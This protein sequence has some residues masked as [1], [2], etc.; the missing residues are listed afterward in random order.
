MRLD[1][2][3]GSQRHA[4]LLLTR[5]KGDDQMFASITLDTN[6]FLPTVY[7]TSAQRVECDDALPQPPA[8]VAGVKG[9][10]P[11][12]ELSGQVCGTY[13][14]ALSTLH[15][16]RT[17]AFLTDQAG[18]KLPV[19]V[20][21]WIELRDKDI[22]VGVLIPFTQV[23]SFTRWSNKIFSAG[24]GL[25]T[26]ST[27]MCRVDIGAPQHVVRTSRA[28]LRSTRATDLFP[29]RRLSNLVPAEFRQTYYLYGV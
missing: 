15:L 23:V 7:P 17:E 20:F 29:A 1:H 24:S 27:S 21:D 6:C 10:P 12:Q 8:L 22:C 28:C 14:S 2:F 9:E 25:M 19:I 13:E 4:S 16:Q 5:D 18:I 3:F 26:P 11:F